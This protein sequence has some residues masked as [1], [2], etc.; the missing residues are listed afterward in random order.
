[1]TPAQPPKLTLCTTESGDV[2]RC[3]GAL[4]C[5]FCGHPAE[6]SNI[7]DLIDGKGTTCDGCHR[8]LAEIERD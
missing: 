3:F 8:S 5:R 7:V 6:A 4:V 2:V 1:V